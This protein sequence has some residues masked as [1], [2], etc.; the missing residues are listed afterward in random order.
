MKKLFIFLVACICWSK[1]DAQ[2]QTYSVANAHSHNDYEN[3][4]PFYAAYNAGFGSMEADIFLQNNELFVAHDTRE[5]LQHRTL[6]QYYLLPLLSALQKNKGYPFADTSRTLQMLIDI[7]TDPVNTLNKLIN[8]LE[9]YPLF[10]NNRSIR[11]V[12]TGN[13][14]DPTQFNI[15][16]AFIGFDGE[17]NREY[18]R[19]ALLKIDL[20]SADLKHFADWDGKNEIPEADENRLRELIHR[21]HQQ[22]KPVR[23]WDAPDFKNA[24]YELMLLE[25]DFINTDHIE[26]L[27]KFLN[28]K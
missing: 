10:T 3:P 1:T 4:V 26:A 21:A 23:F 11:W 24:W 25:V 8:T 16:P 13:R 6:E 9:K 5:L 27:A 28:E 12:I 7:K 17:L 19:E 15:Y 14:P 2:P 20:M 22:H 18:S